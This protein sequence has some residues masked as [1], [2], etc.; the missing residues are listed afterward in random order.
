[1]MD[2]PQDPMES[3]LR[4]AGRRV[5]YPAA[6]DLWPA[7]SARMRAPDQ[8]PRGALVRRWAPALVAVLLLGLST[9][10]VPS[11]RAAVAR[12]LQVG[13]IRVLVEP[14]ATPEGPTALPD[15]SP[16]ETPSPSPTPGALRIPPGLADVAGEAGLE[17]VRAAL[18]E[19]V[20]LPT[21]PAD[22]G[23]PDLVF[24][25]GDA[26]AF[27]LLVWLEP[28]APDRVRLALHILGPL[29][30]GAKSSPVVV[31]EV[32]VNDSWGLWMVGSH[33]LLLRDGEY[34]LRSLVQGNV[35][36]WQVGETTYRLESSLPFDE[37]SR[38]AESLR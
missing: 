18:G 13:V 1:M 11:V 12:V 6:P 27:A 5:T 19:A 17:Q 16:T 28:G 22:L 31:E 33:L 36:V 37:A 38:V 21:Y 25:Q 8:P 4:E 29:A 34:E 14:T 23:G 26:R 10:A 15:G 24:L 32:R 7:I 20:R 3:R 35:L 9:L 30:F 2:A